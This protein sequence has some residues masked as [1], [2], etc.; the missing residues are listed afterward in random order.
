MKEL[1]ALCNFLM[2][3]KF[4]IEQEIDFET[5][6]EEQELYIKDLQKNQALYFKAVEEGCR[7]II[8]F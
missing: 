5:P 1:A 7:N 6:D 2:P 8:A 3:G 4:D